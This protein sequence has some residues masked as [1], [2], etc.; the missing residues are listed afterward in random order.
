MIYFVERLH[1][2]FG[3]V[4]VGF[5]VKRSHHFFWSLLDFLFD[6]IHDS[7]LRGSV[8]F[9]CGEVARFC[10]WSVCMTFL[11]GEFA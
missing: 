6:R 7:F 9:F 8:I 10:V 4:V 5:S 2:L 3:R 1:V 11:W